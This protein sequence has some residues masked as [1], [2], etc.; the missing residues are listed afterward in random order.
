MSNKGGPSHKFAQTFFLAEQPNG[1]YVLNDVFRFL[2]EEVEHDFAVE[3]NAVNGNVA[4]NVASVAA[5]APAPVATT[6]AATTPVSPVRHQPAQ[7]Q[8]PLSPAKEVKKDQVPKVKEEIK[9]ETPV[10]AAPAP[11]AVKKEEPVV[12]KKQEPVVAAPAKKEEPAPAKKEEVKKEEV[13]AKKPV[14]QQPQQTQPSQPP[15][16]KTWANLA[17]TNSESWGTETTAAKVA[18]VSVSVTQPQQSQQKQQ[19]QQQQQQTNGTKDGKDTQ[20]KKPNTA[21]NDR[22]KPSSDNNVIYIKGVQEGMGAIAIKQ[23]FNEFAPVKHVDLVLAKNCAFIE[24]QSV[25][26]AR[27]ALNK[28]ITVN[29]VTMVAEERRRYNKGGRKA[30]GNGNTKKE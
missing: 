11:V 29:G 2:K 18:A 27:K 24:F 19:Q 23:A 25:E 4:P 20:N 30:T 13:A 15:K 8:K 16:P 7:Q 3:T 14:A 6:A 26:G 21:A 22:S 12:V 10:V 28:T 1:Y 5:S 17:A 9:K